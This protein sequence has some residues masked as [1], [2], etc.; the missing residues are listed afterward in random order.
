MKPFEQEGTEKTAAAVG[1]DDGEPKS[2]GG[3]PRV[4]SAVRREIF[5]AENHPRNASSIGTTSA[6]NMPLL[7]S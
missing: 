4:F 2:G 3:P 5:V 6:G 1:A 7:R